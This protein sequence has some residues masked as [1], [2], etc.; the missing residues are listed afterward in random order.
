M[1]LDADAKT[2][3]VLNTRDNM[4]GGI[5]D[6]KQKKKAQLVVDA[7]IAGVNVTKVKAS[8][9]AASETAA[10]NKAY[11]KM[12]LLSTLGACDVSSAIS[13]RR[14]LLADTVYLVEI[15]LSL[16]EVTQLDIDAALTTLSAA[17]IIAETSNEDSLVLLSNIPGIDSGI[18]KTF[19]NEVAAAATATAIAEAAEND[20][21]ATESATAILEADATAAEKVAVDIATEAINLDNEAAAAAMLVPPPSPPYPPPLIP[22]SPSSA[23]SFPIAVIAGA[24]VGL[25]FL[26]LGLTISILAVFYKS[27]FR[28]KLIQYGCKCL[29]NFV[30]PDLTDD[31][32]L[33]A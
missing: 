5:T 28:R 11:L 13:D 29:A 31:A 9:S 27:F 26:G 23:S 2:A 17:G 6:V 7:A 22:T 8:F 12:D 30:V 3:Q 19:Q 32:H 10:C 25:G 15:L 16:A 24:L 33:K 4:L 14:H 18:V 20:A 21:V 1:K